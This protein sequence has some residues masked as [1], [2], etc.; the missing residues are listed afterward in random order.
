MH[1]AKASTR[2]AEDYDPRMINSSSLDKVTS[3]RACLVVLG[4]ERE[5]PEA[6]GTGVA[7]TCQTGRADA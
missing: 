3:T 4:H 5:G 7:C 2:R 1:F 6:H